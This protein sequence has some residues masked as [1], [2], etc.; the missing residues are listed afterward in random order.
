MGIKFDGEFTVTSSPADA[1]AFLADPENVDFQDL[2]SSL[3]RRVLHRP[4]GLAARTLQAPQARCVRGSHYGALLRSDRRLV[5][6]RPRV[7]AG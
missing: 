2:L 1:Y 7:P 5:E 6:T 4:S 3:P